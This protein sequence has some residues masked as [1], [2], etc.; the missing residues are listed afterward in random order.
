MI[1]NTDRAA[2]REETIST[3]CKT[4]EY[5]AESVDTVGEYTEYGTFIRRVPADE[6]GEYKLDFYQYI[7]ELLLATI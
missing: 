7:R 4:L 6:L 3:L 5:L 2:I 1:D